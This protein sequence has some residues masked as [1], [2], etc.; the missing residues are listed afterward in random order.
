MIEFIIRYWI[1]ILFGLIVS[2]L[3]ILFK[4]IYNTWKKGNELQKAEEKEALIESVKTLLDDFREK[5]AQ[6]NKQIDDINKQVDD[7]KDKVNLVVS[8]VLSIQGEQFK[9]HCSS[10]LEPS[11]IITLEEFESIELEHQVYNSLGGNHIGDYLFSLVLEKYKN[12]L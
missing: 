9:S 1:Q 10:L 5:D 2:G 6:I 12:S 3:G 11:H 8:G 7:I 4:T